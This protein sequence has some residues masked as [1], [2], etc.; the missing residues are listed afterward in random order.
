MC[1]LSPIKHVFLCQCVG[2]ANYLA[3]LIGGCDLKKVGKH[4]FSKSKQA[5]LENRMDQEH[6]N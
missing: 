1:F 2:V 3:I 6:E 5:V 4:R